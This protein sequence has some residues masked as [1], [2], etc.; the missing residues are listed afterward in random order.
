M[1]L[2][3]RNPFSSIRLQPIDRLSDVMISMD[4]YGDLDS[5]LY[6][7]RLSHLVGRVFDHDPTDFLHLIRDLPCR[8]GWM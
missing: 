7:F 4:R 8:S 5:H 3:R 1:F 2:T 6:L